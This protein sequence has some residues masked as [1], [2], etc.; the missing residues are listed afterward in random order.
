M[1]AEDLDVEHTGG[2][3]H[4]AELLVHGPGADYFLPDPRRV[5]GHKPLEGRL[6]GLRQ[7]LKHRVR[8]NHLPAR[9]PAHLGQVEHFLDDRITPTDKAEKLWSPDR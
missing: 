9:V 1:S 3:Q 8:L 2:H 6:L 7:P 4:R 5:L